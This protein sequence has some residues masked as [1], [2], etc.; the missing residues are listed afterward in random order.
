MEIALI[1]LRTGRKSVKSLKNK[2]KKLGGRGRNKV[3]LPVEESSKIEKKVVKKVIKMKNRKCDWDRT[4][5]FDCWIL[6]SLE[7]ANIP[8]IYPIARHVPLCTIGA[9]LPSHDTLTIQSE[10]LLI[11]IIDNFFSTC[12]KVNYF[13]PSPVNWFTIIN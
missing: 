8:P 7:N 6:D 10:L 13:T 11:I 3:E 4:T 9:L 5:T 12:I 2:N 1:W